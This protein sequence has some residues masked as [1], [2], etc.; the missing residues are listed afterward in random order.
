MTKYIL[1]IYIL[2]NIVFNVN[3]QQS[4]TYVDNGTSSTYTLGENETLLIASGTFEGSVSNFPSSAIIIV[5]AGA[6]FSP[7]T[8]SNVQGLIQNKGT[9][10]FTQTHNFLENFSVINEDNAKITISANQ[11]FSGSANITNLK[12]GI[13]SC[14][15]NLNLPAGSTFANEGIAK[16]ESGFNIGNSSTYSNDGV[17]SIG[18]DFITSGIAYNGGILKVY[19]SSTLES[20]SQVINK[21]TFLCKGSFSNNSSK[22]ENYGYIDIFG[23]STF[24]NN[25]PFFND[26]KGTLQL[27]NFENNS[28][29]TG[30]G[31]FHVSGS[32]INNGSF[33]F[34][35]GSILFYDFTQNG[36][37]LFDIQTIPP[38][39]SVY[40]EEIGANDTT[41]VSANCNKIA[42]PLAP[43]AALPVILEKFTASNRN[44]IP[45]LE[46]TTTQ[47]INSA[48]FE[49][50]RKAQAD[51]E[52][53]KV[54]KMNA[55]INS[56]GLSKYEFM[57]ESIPNGFYQYRLK[58][59]DLD[60]N[61]TYSRVATVQM[62]CGSENTV[63]VFPNPCLNELNIAFTSNDDDSYQVCIY[64]V[65]GRSFIQKTYDFNTGFNAIKLNINQLPSGNYFVL[66]TNSI[67][68]DKIKFCKF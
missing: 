38:H 12:S 5:A 45:V 66:L 64:D 40:R 34:D 42:F 44:C 2:L 30:G 25:Q 18:G 56:S 54:G 61:I 15:S 59:V 17:M 13:F 53:T 32:S 22:F 43:N 33:G 48:Y 29:V 24:I 23:E 41:Y 31:Q 21:C 11:V 47:E 37:Q 20:N 67:K 10:Y 14:S 46:W 3:A 52:F 49:I 39:V 27:S 35:G 4:Y 9:I 6:T 55:S 50:E 28:E 68:T 57:D 63:N 7:T 65:F 58:M 51:N 62:F 1:T 36:N 8:F 60:G 19:G 16:L 26:A